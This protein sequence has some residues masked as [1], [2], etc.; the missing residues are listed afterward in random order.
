MRK[1]ISND[2]RL[3]SLS[4]ITSPASRNEERRKSAHL[5]AKKSIR[6][7]TYKKKNKENPTGGSPSHTGV[8]DME[9][10]CETEEEALDAAY[11]LGQH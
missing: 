7:S 5:S 4:S 1:I 2:E 3:F 10:S 8:G 11:T 6:K 9:Q